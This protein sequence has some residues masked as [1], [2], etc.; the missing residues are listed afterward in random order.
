MHFVLYTR[1]VVEDKQGNGRC[2]LYPTRTEMNSIDLLADAS[3]AYFCFYANFEIHWSFELK[4]S[5]SFE[6][7]WTFDCPRCNDVCG[8]GILHGG[9]GVRQVR[10]SL[11]LLTWQSTISVADELSLQFLSYTEAPESCCCVF[12]AADNGRCNVFIQRVK[13]RHPRTP[14]LERSEAGCYRWRIRGDGRFACRRR[15][16]SRPGTFRR[17]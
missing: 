2:G 12:V 17:L 11:G 4:Y 14:L 15:P 6:I 7:H 9:R 5:R 8:T 16:V 13:R 10:E 3:I 1:C